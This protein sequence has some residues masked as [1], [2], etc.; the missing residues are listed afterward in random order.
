MVD[1]QI[2]KIWSKRVLIKKLPRLNFRY[3]YVTKLYTLEL[4]SVTSL[5]I[6][7]VT[8]YDTNV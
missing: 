1:F 2:S 4:Y 6:Q 8:L 7:T 3:R 5:K